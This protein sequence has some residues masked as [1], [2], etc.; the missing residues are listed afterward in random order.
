MKSQ[1]NHTATNFWFGFTLGISAAAGAL[2][3]LGTKKGRETVHKILEYSEDIP[4]K[5]PK[6]IEELQLKYGG[7]STQNKVK[8]GLH[9]LD[10]IITKI[11]ETSQ[12]K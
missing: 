8:E 9:T 11:K 2:Y 7:S 5:L 3:L 1:N 10:N 4:E 12:H 6:L